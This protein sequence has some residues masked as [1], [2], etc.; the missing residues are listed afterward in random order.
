MI[1]K[2]TTDLQGKSEVKTNFENIKDFFTR[3]NILP[4]SDIK[5]IEAYNAQLE[6]CTSTQTAFN[7]TMLNAS[8][9]AQKI[10]EGAN[11]NTVAL[12]KLTRASKAS[13]MGMQALSA[14]GN[15]IAGVVLA[16]II[17]FVANIIDG[18]IHQV[19]KANE[20][21][22]KALSEYESAKSSLEGINSELADQNEKMN[23]LLAKDHLTY[24]EKGQLKEL[25][26]ITK[27]LMIQQDIEEKGAE[28]ASKEAAEK[29][30]KAYDKQFGKYDLSKESV[31]ELIAAE[32]FPLPMSE[33]DVVGNIAAFTR[34]GQ[35]LQSAQED[36]QRALE[37]G[38]DTAWYAMSAQLYIDRKAELS[39]ILNTNL[40]DMQKKRFALEEEYNKAIEKRGN[41]PDLL[42]SLE[43]DIIKTYEEASEGIRLIYEYTNQ[44]GWNDV[45]ISSIF[46]TDGIEKTKS[47][48][49]AMAKAG[50]LTPEVVSGYE[51]LNEAI[52]NSDIFLEEGQ[53]LAEAFCEEIYALADA[54][55]KMTEEGNGPSFDPSVYKDTLSDIQSTISTLRSAL[56]SLNTGEL[57]QTQV[58]DLMQQFPELVPYIDLTAEGFGNLSEGLNALISQKPDALIQE[59]Q[60]LKD[61]L[62]TEEEREQVE[63]LIDSLQRLS[64]YGDTGVE[65]YA[66]AIGNT[67]NDT[68]NVISGVTAQF[69]N[70]AKVQEAVADGLT[71]SAEAAAELAKMY[72]EI[73]TNAI[74][75]GDG[76]ITLNEAVVGSILEGDQSIIDAQIAKLEAD[77]AGLTAKKAFAEGQLNIIKQTAEGEGSI[78]KE[79]A[80]YRIDA[81][82]ALL[83]ALIDAGLEE[84]KA[85]AAVAANMAG[86][87]DEFNRIAGEAAKDISV[88][89]GN[90]AEYMAESMSN[91]SKNAQESLN[92]LQKKVHDLALAIQGTAKG[93]LAGSLEIY[94]GGGAAKGKGIEVQKSTG[95][96][97]E[98]S[99]QYTPVTVSLEDFK[100]Q[101]ELDIKG[102]TDAI[103][104]I[105]SQIQVLKNLQTSF[106]AGGIGGH[107]YAEKIKQLE[108]E[109]SQIND[110]MKA[111][112]DPSGSGASSAQT[113]FSE[114]L[115]FFERR[116][117]ALDN[118]LSLLKSASDNVSGAFAKNTLADAQLAVTEEKLKNYAEAMDMYS[119]KAGEALAKLPA[120]TA[121]LVKSGAVALTDFVGDENKNVVEAIKEYESWAGKVTDCRQEL[122]ELQKTLRQ[123]ELE[124][125]NQ[126]MDDFNDKFSLRDKGKSLISKQMDLLKEAGELT[127]SA[128]YTAQIDQSKKQLALLEEEKA[129]LAQQ[130]ASALGSGRIRKGTEE[131]LEMAGALADVEGNILDCKKTIEELDNSLL[132]LHTEVFDRIQK[133][134][135]D[136]DSE[137]SRLAG[138]FEDFDP[139]DDKGGWTGEGLARLGLLVQQYELARYQ[140][141]QYNHEIDEL[142]ARYLEGRYSASEYADRLA[143]LSSAQWEAVNASQSARDAIMDLNEARINGAVKGIEKEIDSYKELTDARLE[144]LRASRELHDYENS[145][146]EKTKSVTDLE[147]RIAAMQYDTSAAAAAKRRQL[148]EELAEARKAL[149][150]AEYDHSLKTQEEALNSQYESY[151]EERR[152]EIEGL[153]ESLNEKETIL[154]ESFETVKSNAALI[155]WEIANMAALQGAAVS[156]TLISSWQSGETAVASYGETLSQNTSAF[157][158]S[159]VGVEAEVWN[160]QAQADNTAS[161]L[162]WMFAARADSLVN[163]LG[164]SYYAE[165]NLAGMTNTLQQVLSG[166]LERG[167][168]VSGILS[169]LGSITSAANAAA[170]AVESIG[171][172][173]RTGFTG[174]DPADQSRD[175]LDAFGENI[176]KISSGGGGGTGGLHSQNLKPT[177]MAML[178]AY[179][180]GTRA[181]EGDLIVTDEEGEELKL[182]RLENGQYTVAREGTQI[183]TKRQ[184][185]NLFQWSGFSPE[186]LARLCSPINIP[187][188]VLKPKLPEWA[189]PSEEL[190]NKL[191]D[192]QPVTVHYDSLV[193]V[194]GDVNDTNHFTKQV[195]KIARQEIDKD[196]QTLND[197]VK[198]RSI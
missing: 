77:K 18:A 59:L 39:K 147:R 7:R 111:G 103:S 53:S 119:Q 185:D 46:S 54:S 61:S 1:F 107:G 188:S 163:E 114:T 83:K 136:I 8:D 130:A 195:A 94:E 154:G 25:Q 50:N 73:L 125:F 117:K 34:A 113:Q 6:E 193:T 172:G 120:D 99:T 88:N 62:S 4:D 153:R 181:T 98:S 51:K 132:N 146:A 92:N 123:L 22:D 20:E 124:K 118:A 19:E 24:A 102:Y 63:L 93:V 36:Y 84:D 126:I 43:K 3:K 32:A 47:E 151:E 161:S 180:G 131:W 17:G 89:M 182:P 80:Q 97:K 112:T 28:N 23:E 129:Q 72:P 174:A 60:T 157:I 160:L 52:Q 104:N 140:I 142:K 150:E 108:K 42:E 95:S 16:K 122:E 65:A 33:N 152:K 148:E 100:S 127:G 96:F 49:I 14:A 198:Y 71:L 135:S 143:D 158:G 67:W 56:D 187:E 79:T 165:S 137:I 139:A 64:S 58:L 29:T 45:E 5:A 91:N 155:G 186:E 190:L 192:R 78:T 145:I 159:L 144:A 191:M 2:T 68:A 12:E 27:E 183:L 74:D 133:Q 162:A 87:T 90:A 184:T 109:K 106:D 170:K 37:T 164:A 194:N 86:N 70:L 26:A 176:K 173:S 128:F 197:A 178:H 196:W 75:A 134:F 105:D 76:Q 21:M 35:L 41:T 166:T 85:Y 138:L 44:A 81:A 40:S 116:V 179:A 13:A 48:L 11:G 177:N 82:N 156:E 15:M 30:V 175:G 55:K 189:G 149:E 69:E 57:D 110:A 101:L 115:D 167:Y 168:N 31:D 38:E 10:V 121:A 141:Q 169:S 171:T 9:A 66:A